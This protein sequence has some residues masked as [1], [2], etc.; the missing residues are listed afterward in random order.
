MRQ[1]I[2]DFFEVMWIPTKIH[3]ARW[4]DTFHTNPKG[5]D[6][7]DQSAFSTSTI[8]TSDANKLLHLSNIQP[9]KPIVLNLFRDLNKKG[10]LTKT[11][12]KWS[13]LSQFN[14]GEIILNDLSVIQNPNSYW[15][16]IDPVDDTMKNLKLVVKQ[17]A[18]T[19]NLYAMNNTD[20][21]NSIY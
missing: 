3:M 15:T 7:T 14:T 12:M 6:V 17:I 11:K 13:D 10:V 20:R 1:P 19:R 18:S 5:T 2:E 16:F 8:S 9:F 21:D 4:Y